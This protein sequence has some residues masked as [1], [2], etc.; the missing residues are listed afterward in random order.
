MIEIFDE[1]LAKMVQ[2]RGL[3]G[4]WAPPWGGF[5]GFWAA[6]GRFLAPRGLLGDL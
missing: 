5:G 3:E 4:V 2:N 6:F 1:I